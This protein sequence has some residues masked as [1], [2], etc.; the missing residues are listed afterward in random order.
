[1][2]VDWGMHDSFTAGQVT[3]RLNVNVPYTRFFLILYETFLLLLCSYFISWNMIVFYCMTFNGLISLWCF[4]QGLIIFWWNSLQ[5]LTDQDCCV[6]EK[7]WHSLVAPDPVASQ[8]LSLCLSESIPV[9]MN[10]IKNLHVLNNE[11]VC[12]DNPDCDPRDDPGGRPPGPARRWVLQGGG[13]DQ[14][15]VSRNWKNQGRSTWV[16]VLGLLTKLSYCFR[17]MCTTIL[18]ALFPNQT[19]SRSAARFSV[20]CFISE[21]RCCL[22]S[23]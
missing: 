23:G 6:F 22:G 16:L 7:F 20:S 19:D 12:P 3:E 21:T 5:K 18:W 8:H 2:T 4:R 11:A 15:S 1:M 14:K 13:A 9:S 10:K 17:L